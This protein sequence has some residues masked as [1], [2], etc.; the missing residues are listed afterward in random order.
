MLMKNKIIHLLLISF[1]FSMVSILSSCNNTSNIISDIVSNK[2]TAKD[3]IDSANAQATRKY[4]LNAKLV[5]VL[6][7]NVIFDG[8]DKGRTD[9]GIISAVS[10]PNTLGA[11]IYVFKKPGT[12]TLAVYTPNP[13]PGARDCIELTKFFSTNTLI[14]LISDTSARN[15]VQGAISLINNSNFNITTSSS[16]L[17]DSD[18]S[19]D[20]ANSSN[21]VIKFNSSFVPSSSTLNG[22]GFFTGTYTSKTVNM[23]LIPAAGTLNLP[24]YITNLL[25]FPND[26]W[27]VNY[28]RTSGSSTDNLILG[29]VVQSS[30]QMGI[31]LLGLVSKAINL[32]KFV[33]Q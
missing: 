9:I 6:G 21:P 31:T 22:N 23:F 25:G 10:D 27:V 15:I 18:I 33:N 32:S 8:T 24:N 4:G 7:Q 3:R 29:T 14:G 12:D 19:L 1:A 2:V 26:L 13:I 5:L 17:V 28:K 16:N 11:W 30:Q 20:Y